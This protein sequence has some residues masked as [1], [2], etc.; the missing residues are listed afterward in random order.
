MHA[1]D[2]IIKYTS[3]ADLDE[4]LHNSLTFNLNLS[5]LPAANFGSFMH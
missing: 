1:N 4:E 5:P 2:V 3:I